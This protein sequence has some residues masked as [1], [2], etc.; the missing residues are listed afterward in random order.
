MKQQKSFIR[1]NAKLYLVAT[2][3]GNLEDITFR[4]INT[5][6]N[7]DTIYCEDTRTSLKLL[8]HYN[9]EKPLKSVHLFNEQ[10]ITNNIIQEIKKGKNVALIS[11]A[12]MPLISDPGG[13]LTKKAI[14]EDIDVIIIPGPSAGISALVASGLSCAKYLFLGFLNS[15]KNKRREE[16]KEL[17]K[18]EETIILYEAPHRIVDTLDLIDEL[19]DDRLIVL[20]RELTK[21]HE[22]YL[23]GTAKEIKEKMETI[24]G[25]MVIII[26]GYQKVVDMNIDDTYIYQKYQEYL[27]LDYSSKDAIKEVSTVLN[28]NKN[29]VYD[30]VKTHKN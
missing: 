1:D 8:K 23:R 7:V 5:L 15:K 16:L 26:D 21:I 10:E 27:N 13:F 20:A 18:R 2:P 12:G 11:D 25:E 28:I 29:K 30:I 9:I 4:A 17:V 19:F 22:E 14:D 24:K 6:N 3:I